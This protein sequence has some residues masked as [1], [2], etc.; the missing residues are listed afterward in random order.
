MVLKA[1]P[2]KLANTRFTS[3]FINSTANFYQDRYRTEQ[4]ISINMG[5]NDL[6][7]SLKQALYQN[8]SCAGETRFREEWEKEW[9]E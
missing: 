9:K 3:S 1:A 4:I 5:L 7:N 8:C 6:K 2:P